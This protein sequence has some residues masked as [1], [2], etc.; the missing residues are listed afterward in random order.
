V[1]KAALDD[2]A[3]DV[4]WGALAGPG[5]ELRDGLADEHLDAADGASAGGLGLGEKPRFHWIVDGVEDQVI[6]PERGGGLA[7][8]ALVDVGAHTDGGGVDDD[9]A[10]AVAKA[11]EG[12]SGDLA[13]GL[14]ELAGQFIGAVPG[15]V[16]DGDGCAVM[17]ESCD[18][19]SAGAA[20]A[21][22]GNVSAGEV[23]PGDVKL[24][25]D[26]VEDGGVVGV[27]AAEARGAGSAVD[28]DGVDGADGLG[29]RLDLGVFLPEVPEGV[30]LVWDGDAEAGEVQAI[31]VDEFLDECLEAFVARLDEEG[32]VDAVVVGGVEG[33][34]VDGGGHGVF[35]GV[36]DDAVDLG[37]FGDEV[38]AVEFFHVGDGDLTWGGAGVVV[39]GAEGEEGAE[40]LGEDSADESVLAHAEGDGGFGFVLEDFKGFEVVA[41]GAG[42]PDDFGDG[43][44]GGVEF[45]EDVV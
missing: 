44:G 42:G 2:L 45:V 10:G 30:L 14:A 41:D 26:A 4:T 17:G 1:G 43:G 32:E 15:A 39:E 23:L 31:E 34:V 28:D 21:E 9:G 27:D 3:H 16:V 12:R 22:D 19:G 36:C 20:G 13:G 24:G 6:G 37:F 35:H 38:P 40:L 33:S 5:L 11:L 7:E 18:S 8:R 25:G 29:E